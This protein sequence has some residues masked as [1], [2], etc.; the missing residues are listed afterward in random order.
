MALNLS[1]LAATASAKAYGTRTS[2]TPLHLDTIEGL[3]S[4]V[5]I[6][7]S[8][9]QLSEDGSQNLSLYVGRVKVSLDVIKKGAQFVTAQADQIE[10]YTE[11]LTNAVN[12]GDFDEALQAAAAKTD[13]ANRKAKPEA[14]AVS[15]ELAVAEAETAEG[16]APEGVDLDELS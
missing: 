14:P 4:R 15:D 9:K 2:V 5:V 13:P 3:R 11:V 1:D 16:A 6:K 10:A 7:D 12:A 8:N